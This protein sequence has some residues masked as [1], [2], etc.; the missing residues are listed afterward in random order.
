MQVTYNARAFVNDDG[1]VT[2]SITI[3]GREQPDK[4]GTRKLSREFALE[5]LS[6]QGDEGER[7]AVEWL[8]KKGWDVETEVQTPAAKLNLM[9]DET[10]AD[11]PDLPTLYREAAAR[12]RALAEQ[13]A[14]AY[15]GGAREAIFACV[16]ADPEEAEGLITYARV[17]P[18]H[19]DKQLHAFADNLEERARLSETEVQ[20][21][22]DKLNLMVGENPTIKPDLPT[23]YREA[24][25]W[26]QALIGVNVRVTELR[27]ARSALAACAKADPET[28]E[29]L[30]V[31]ADTLHNYS[32]GALRAVA[33]DLEKCAR[34]AETA[35]D[36]ASP[37]KL[38]Q[39]VWEALGNGGNAD[40]WSLDGARAYLRGR[41]PST[42]AKLHTDLA[43]RVRR[44]V[45]AQ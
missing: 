43:D 8:K 13:S 4:S 23:L 18:N 35:V 9:V 29:A 10:P 45:E 15:F 31:W 5:I 32:D 26:V 20:S 1:Q 2:V 38:A 44:Y 33:N 24:A 7:A 39:M 11:K 19:N 41:M 17:L 25:R 34:L 12:V 22:A 3:D 40:E 16:K 42:L 36:V 6:K 37:R 27:E 30:I 14:P 28:A 21:P